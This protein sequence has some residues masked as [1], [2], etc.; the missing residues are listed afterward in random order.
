MPKEL[1]FVKQ[2]IKKK[3]KSKP[4]VSGNNQS[5]SG[6]HL[7]Q[8]EIGEQL[9]QLEEREQ[10]LGES[11]EEE[12]GAKTEDEYYDEEIEEEEGD[13]QQTYFDP[14]D[15]FGGDEDDALEDG[16]SY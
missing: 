13:Y 11:E 4:V 8:A 6:K 9:K 1:Y 16:P 3:T 15:D 10:V 14:G 2:R 7:P 5:L 12:G